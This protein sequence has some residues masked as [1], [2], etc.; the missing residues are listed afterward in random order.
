M[1]NSSAMRSVP[2]P[3]SKDAIASVE[4]LSPER[5]SNASSHRVTICDTKV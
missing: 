2:S 3:S 5:R 4:S 1:E